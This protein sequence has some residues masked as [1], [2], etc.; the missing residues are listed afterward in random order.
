LGDSIT[1]GFGMD[2]LSGNFN[3]YR[4]QSW[5]LGADNNATTVY[6]YFKQFSPQL[7]GGSVGKHEVEFCYGP[8]CPPFQYRPELDVLN[9]A[10]S[11][12]MISDLPT[13]E[14]DYLLKILQDNKK[15][16]IKNDW[17]M[18]TVL[19]GAN[20][21]CASCTNGTIRS[22]DEY[23]VHL[24]TTLERVRL[25]IP[26]TFVNLV[27]LLNISQVYTLSLATPYCKDVHRVVFIECSCAFEDGK[28]GDARRLEMDTIGQQYNER[29]RKVAA[30]Y[31]SRNYTDFAV[32]DQPAGR[33]TA[34]SQFPTDFLSTLDCFH[35][36]LTA[37]RLMANALWNSILTPAAKKQT[38]MSPKG[39]D[40]ICPTAD[41]LLYTN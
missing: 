2:G 10:Q 6:N 21:L 3:E 5:A 16:D 38:A 27:E 24:R 31:K 30:D 33:D 32:V 8:V 29:L 4:G 41:T 39:V 15:I 34:I 36:S 22:P 19:I 37:H 9:A 35:P 17:K 28:N 23:E 20:D 25:N 18:L 40:P 13:H 11:G 7:Q 26:R 14:M 1:A 12:A